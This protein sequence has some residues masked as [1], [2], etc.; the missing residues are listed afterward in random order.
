MKQKQTQSLSLL[1]VHMKEAQ[2]TQSLKDGSKSGGSIKTFVMDDCQ[3]E[4]HSVIR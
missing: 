2:M 3:M 4:G 1:S